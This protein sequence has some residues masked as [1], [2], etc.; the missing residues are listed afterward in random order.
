M[1]LNFQKKFSTS[2]PTAFLTYALAKLKIKKKKFQFQAE[3]S[4]KAQ[5]RALDFSIDFVMIVIKM[6]IIPNFQKK[7]W[8]N[9]CKQLKRL[10]FF[11][12][13]KSWQTFT[14]LNLEIFVGDATPEAGFFL[15]P[16]LPLILKIE[17]ISIDLTALTHYFL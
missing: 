17:M 10:Q 12:I 4:V 15:I 14:I 2:F 13:Q 6:Q 9:N 5:N 7:S 11:E 1:S 8:D 3:K 16:E